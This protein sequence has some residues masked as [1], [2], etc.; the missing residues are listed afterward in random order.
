LVT[1]DASILSIHPSDDWTPSSLAEMSAVFVDV[2]CPLVPFPDRPG[3]GR[4]II[5]LIS[6][7]TAFQTERTCVVASRYLLVSGVRHVPGPL[8]LSIYYP[9]NEGLFQSA[10]LRTRPRTCR[11]S[12]VTNGEMW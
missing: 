10:K 2:F 12:A 11:M 8:R 4:E 7:G 6:G 9:W 3:D 1:V 5:K